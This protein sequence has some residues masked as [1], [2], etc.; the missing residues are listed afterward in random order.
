MPEIVETQEPTQESFQSFS[1]DLEGE[2]QQENKPL[3]DIE[4][5]LPSKYRGKSIEEIISMHQEAEK[6]IGRQGQ[7]VS[8]VR[9]LADE[10]IKRDLTKTQTQVQQTADDEIDYFVDPKKAIEKAV[11]NHPK[12]REAEE[13]LAAL[14]NR[15][16]VEELNARHPDMQQILSEPEFSEYVRGN[17]IRT[18]LFERANN[19]YDVDSADELFTTYKMRKQQLKGVVQEGV[20][21]LAEE[22]DKNLKKAAVSTGSSTSAGKRIFRRAELIEW[23][24]RNPQKYLAMQDD[25]TQAYL[26]GRVK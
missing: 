6:V 1:K 17:R 25:I 13:R 8:E 9:R 5:R 20:K 22:A 4:D 23:R 16:A 19:Q 21:E 7:E 18:E 10:L 14:H 12:I 26:E 24:I 11:S 2:P 15:T 3:L